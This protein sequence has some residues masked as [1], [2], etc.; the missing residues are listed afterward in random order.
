MS[1]I[2]KSIIREAGDTGTTRTVL[3]V[4]DTAPT[5]TD[6]ADITNMPDNLTCS[7][8]SVCIDAENGKSYIVGVD[9]DWHELP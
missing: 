1:M 8:G 4:S 9:G 2:A 3:I 7:V 6:G 5:S